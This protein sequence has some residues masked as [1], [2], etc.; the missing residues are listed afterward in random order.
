M[1]AIKDL[2]I[3][4]STLDTGKETHDWGWSLNNLTEGR[5][6]RDEYCL[7]NYSVAYI[8]ASISWSKSHAKYK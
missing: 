4:Y 5:L 8:Y 7:E 1:L 6:Q 3:L 2:H